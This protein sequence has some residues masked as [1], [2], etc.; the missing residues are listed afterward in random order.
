MP[1]L[2]SL[3]IYPI[4]SLDGVSVTQATILQGGA[5][6]GSCRSA[7]SN[8]PTKTLGNNQRPT[9]GDREF[10]IFDEQGKFI[11]GKR[12]PKV[13]QLRTSFD[14]NART[15]SLQVQGMDQEKVFQIDDERIEL[16]TWLSNYFSF[17]VRVERALTSFPDDTNAPGPTIISTGTLKQVASWFPGISVDELRSRLRANIEIGEVP[18]FWE[19]QLF[20]VEDSIVQFQVGDIQFEGINPCQRCVVPSR[21]PLTG[22]VYP[23]FQKTFAA[24]RRENLPPW[25]TVSRFNHFFKLAVNTRVPESEIGKTLQV[26]DH[27]KILGI[28]KIK[29]DPKLNSPA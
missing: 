2:T 17:P 26:G 10:A 22:K 14:L 6:G 27:L 15:V 13:H 7:F 12:N 3:L 28:R 4:K 16:E 29:F 20:T 5:L 9:F 11:N 1:Y 8:S 25:V 21:D 19:D 23:S 24:Q 18:P